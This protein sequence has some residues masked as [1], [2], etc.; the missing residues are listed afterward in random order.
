MTDS[1]SARAPIT[2]WADSPMALIIRCKHCRRRMP[3]DATECPACQCTAFIYQADWWPRGRAGGRKRKTL[4]VD[5][6]QD[7]LEL[8]K[9]I[10]GRH[11]E[12]AVPTALATVGELFPGYL[13]WYA[14]H[15]ATT[16]L[17]DV[18]LTWEKSI[19]PILGGY[20]VEEIDN[21]HISLYQQ[22]RAGR[23]K[24]RTVNK[25]LDYFS[26]FLKWCRREKKIV[27]ARIEYEKLPCSRPLPIIL[28]P[29]EV[30]RIIKAAEAE[31][32]YRA[33]F[34]CLY[35]LGFR[36]SEVRWLRLEDFDFENM[37]VKVTQK[38][39]TEKTLPLSD[40][41][42]EAVKDLAALWPMEA[43][44][45]LFGLKKMEGR[46]IGDI[47]AAIRRTCKAAGVMKRVT[48]HTFRHSIASHLM[49]A[50][51]NASII[52]KFLGH[53]QLAT[54]QFY[55]HVSMGNLRRAQ[56]LFSVSTV[57]TE[58]RR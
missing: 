4:P 15:R 3:Q 11:K 17:R 58:N 41:V 40:Q 24:N 33:F 38:G 8:E 57:S 47:R 48:P 10:T 5:S 6:L 53:K 29:E 31:P 13:K 50:D 26:G 20:R 12:T 23:V 36:F 54:T 9:V 35:A 27:V 19:K 1:A 46:P 42:V 52:Q 16:T 37:V 21:Q 28:S 45:Y 55:S 51:V 32:F 18:N 43:G 56:G 2:F 30:V 49:G 34:L 44:A 25:E 14:I 39:G 7:A 22:S